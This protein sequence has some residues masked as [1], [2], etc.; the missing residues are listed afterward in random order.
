MA[1]P[2]CGESA[3]RSSGQNALASSIR[4]ASS[5]TDSRR[6]VFGGHEAEHGDLV[7]RKRAAGARTSRNARRRTRAAAVGP[8][9]REEALRQ[10]VVPALDEPS[11]RLVSTAQVH[12]ERDTFVLPID[13]VVE[14]E[15]EIEPTLRRPAPAR[16]EVAVGR[17]DEQRV[18]RRVEL[19]VGGAQTDE[20]VDLL[21]QDLGDRAEKLLEGAVGA[22]RALR[23]PEVGEH[24]GTGE[25]H[26]EHP[27]GPPPRVRELLG[28]EEAPTTEG[29]LDRE[30][31]PIDVH[32]AELV[33]VPLAP[34][35]RVEVPLAE[36]FDRL[37]HLA[38]EGEATHLAVRDDVE[39]GLLLQAKRGVDGGVLDPFEL[40]GRQQAAVA[41]L[42]GLEQISGPEQA[43]DDVGPGL[44]HRA[45]LCP[46]LVVESASH[47]GNLRRPPA[48]LARAFPRCARRTR[49]SSVALARR[50]RDYGGT[51]PDRP[52]G[53]R[54]GSAHPR[55]R[56][57]R[58]R[59]RR[60]LA[61]SEPW[62]RSAQHRRASTRSRRS[63]PR[64]CSRSRRR[65]MGASPRSHL[66]VCA[67]A[68]SG[69]LRWS[70]DVRST[71]TA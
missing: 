42:A 71:S 13:E 10:P 64:A 37:R 1:K 19:N 33:R 29:R 67:T 8:D 18:V 22:R 16:I 55:S 25:R 69:C 48:P 60:A 44:D 39:P 36:P 41:S 50:A 11:A 32:L 6:P 65:A 2:H 56:P 53:A 3:S 5:S 45:T 51:L 21:A 52:G 40:G 28:G 31:R 23:I 20:L 49:C 59:R 38:L 57:G 34:E 46:R 9:A 43:A 63:G 58:D 27:I 4:E 15:A 24:A 54:A 7:L 68:S 26:L 17:V 14:L 35:E 47:D 30:R 66:R 70:L 12:R 61:A 62:P